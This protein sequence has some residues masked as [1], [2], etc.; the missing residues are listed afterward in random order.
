MST[1]TT[2][3]SRGKL[4]ASMPAA[5]AAVPTVASALCRRPAEGDDPIF[6]L[7]AEHREAMRA[8][9]AAN[10]L[11]SDLEERLPPEQREWCYSAGEKGPPEDCTD[12]PEWIT[13]EIAVGDAYER[14]NDSLVAVLETRPPTLAGVLALLEHATLPCFPEE[15]NSDGNQSILITARLSYREDVR[16]AADDFLWVIIDALRVLTGA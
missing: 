4:L 13:A 5:A 7:I 12:A 11:H 1:N 2:N 8:V 15:R 9:S 3:L 10:S 6:A 14:M 16:D